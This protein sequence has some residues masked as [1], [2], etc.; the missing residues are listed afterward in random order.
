MFKNKKR[1]HLLA[2]LLLLGIF[3][4]ACQPQEVVREV[5]VEVT[6]VVTETVTEG[7]AQVEVTRVIT[8]EVVVTATPEPVAPV[9]FVAP[10]PTT[11]T[12]LTFGDIST[13][14]PNLAYDTASG[15]LIE[16]V[17]ETLIYYNHT[18]GT[19]YVPQLATEVPSLENGGISEDGLT[20]TFN[21]RQG[22]TFHNGSDLTPSDFAYTFHRGLLQSDP[23]GPQW[24]LLEPLL[25][26]SSCS[27][28][29]EGID[30]ECG[31]AGDR[32]ALL[33]GATPEQL[34]ATCE[35]VKASVV[36]DDDAGTLT[37]H[38]VAPWG[39]WLATLAQS[40]GAA[41]DQE[42][43][44][45]NGAWDGDC[46]TWQ[47]FYAP[48]AENDELSAIINGTG[49]YMLDH[50]TPG[51]E[52]VLVA[53]PNYWRAEGDV[54]W[55][56]GP[57]GEARIKTVIV[58]IVDEFGTRFAA[59]Q[60]GDAES[61]AANIEDYVQ[62]DPLVGEHCD[63][64]T[65]EC[66][67][68]AEHPDGQLRKWDNLPSV[69]RTDIFLNFNVATDESGANAYIGS[70]QLDGNGIPPDFFSDINVRRAFAQCFDYET[71]IA[72]ALDGRGVRNNGPIIR[73]MLGYNEDG[74]M[75]EYNLDACAEE[76][77]Q[78]WGGVLPETGFRLQVAYNTGNT[79]RQT[80][81]EI[82]QTNLASVNPNY[83]IEVLGLPWP[84]LL[85]AFRA[86]Q[87]PVAVSGW[88]EDI[89]HP[90]NW[91][92]PFTVGTFAGRQNLPDDLIGQFRELVNAGAQEADAAAAEQIYFQLQQLY[93][94][95]VPTIPL[96]Q[97]TAARFEQRWVQDWYNRVGAFGT[98]WYAL[99]LASE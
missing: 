30:P 72:E 44:A 32:E 81:A 85:A 77:A 82:L 79:T 67:A 94:D 55:E 19:T 47:N 22:V 83:R 97:A 98:Y 90:H 13:M 26:Y 40:W 63:W 87:L 29:T 60:A 99:G 45:E 42:W 59:L 86:T 71:Y 25:G 93:Y 31:L 68:D 10:D 80:I 74:P 7:G 15:Q 28:V 39:P 3:L 89:H 17:M 96:A 58:R 53:N 16:N 49:P 21:I 54:L 41:I 43:A 61:I 8:E 88:I 64:Q 35:A 46:A 76:L 33:A 92:Q 84:T 52:Y 91:A 14:D 56:N 62:L 36:A 9:S 6:R 78:A 95:E 27:D 70:G 37:F 20:Y 48:G 51:E 75:Y 73:D 23:N 2:V 4:V 66:T 18:D 50:W 12:A 69:S 11:Y 34:V 65:F 1:S 38:L 24:L 5:P 57:S